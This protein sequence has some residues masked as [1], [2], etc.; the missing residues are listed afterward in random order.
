MEERVDHLAE[1]V[2]EKILGRSRNLKQGIKDVFKKHDTDKSG[3]LELSEFVRALHD[4]LPG[5]DHMEY[6]A[7]FLRFDTDGSGTLDVAEVSQML[8]DFHHGDSAPGPPAGATGTGHKIVPPE[9]TA[10]QGRGRGDES[11]A[12]EPEPNAEE[13]G[14]RARRRRRRG[15]GGGVGLLLHRV[16]AG[17]LLAG[18]EQRTALP[19]PFE[20]ARHVIR[21]VR[22]LLGV[23][24]D[25]GK[26]C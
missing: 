10:A 7:L 17:T 3:L 4:F 2:V 8:F 16:D 24:A 19:L 6:Q 11:G 15:L 18:P 25:G 22:P 21:E 23:G 1:L 20:A 5:Y 13:T 14:R 12:G 9:A 26:E